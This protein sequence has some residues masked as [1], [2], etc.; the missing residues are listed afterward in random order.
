M[1]GQGVGPIQDRT[2]WSCC[3]AILPQVQIIAL[4]ERRA[5]VPLLTACGVAPNRIV[6]TGDDAIELAYRQRPAQPGHG[7]GIN[8]RAASYASVEAAF[9]ERIGPE[10]QTIARRLETSLIPIPISSVPGEE[11]AVTLKGIVCG[12]SSGDVLD[13]YDQRPLAVRSQVFARI[14]QCRIVVTGSYHAA[15]FAL[16]QGIPAVGLIRSA[17]YRDKFLGLADLFGQGCQVVQLHDSSW[18][19]VLQRTIDSVWQ[20]AEATR[21]PL[22]NAALA[23]IDS[24]RQAYDRLTALTAARSGRQSELRM[25][26]V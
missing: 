4:R 18:P 16:S 11:D 17:Y 10:L 14:H 19:E 9:A 1:F 20:S 7:I 25:G 3:R 23:Q 5:G 26:D 22:L 2:L 21:Q 8:L 24:G 6:A 13:G 15:V 12:P